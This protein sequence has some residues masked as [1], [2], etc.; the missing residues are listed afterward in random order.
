[1]SAGSIGAALDRAAQPSF[2]R[3]LRDIPRAALAAL[4]T[5]MVA[6]GLTEGGGL[7]LLVPLLDL[8]QHGGG[9]SPLAR[10]VAPVLRAVGLPMTSGVLLCAFVVMVS[11][12]AWLQNRRSAASTALQLRWVD[13]M[14]GRAF[15]ALIGAEYSWIVRQRQSDQVSLLTSDINRVGVGLNAGLT[16]LATSATSVIYLAAAFLLAPAL[17]LVV[18]ACGGLAWW[19]LAGQRRQSIDLGRAQGQANRALQAQLQETLAGVKLAKIL[20]AER[21]LKAGFTTSMDA[22]REQQMR[23]QHSQGRARALTQVVA[24]V[25]LAG[26]VQVGLAVWG[27]P[28]SELLILAL[29]LARMIPMFS[30]AQQQVHL[31]LNALPA[32]TQIDALVDE[33]E[34]SAEPASAGP[35]PDVAS[36]PWI[37]RDAIELR[38]AT[39]WRDGRAAPALDDLTLRLAPR[40]TTAVIG[41]SGAGKTTLADVLAGLMPLT[42]GTLAVD[43][44]A[45]TGGERLR[46]RHAVAYVTQEV[47][48][49][50]DTVRNNLLWG[51]ATAG[52]DDGLL[53]DALR[54]AAAEFVLA[55]PQGLDTVIGDGG[56]MLSGGER[57]RLA[58]ARALLR[59]PSLLILDEATSALDVDN[60]AR[61]GAALRALHGNLTVLLIGHRLA[62][63]EHADQV[64]VMAHGRIARSG[65]WAAVRDLPERLP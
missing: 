57:Q 56:L 63:L 55:L 40:T 39:L 61:I 65:P 9:T 26:F 62:T 3:L 35:S 47:F 29:L 49:V 11:V 30:T 24:A 58:L 36:T 54:Q 64:V 50:H 28:L 1:M 45:V 33:G 16:L 34:A 46:W 25:F 59:Q 17:T 27:T 42:A 13:E 60:E 22:L 31:L 20:G 32:L 51:M 52:P 18:L 44:V 7:L 38:A 41:A 23:F 5:W 43:G 12:S 4:L 21:L 2:A 8:L 15:S 48:L 53:V 19:W 10:H 14:R 6:A 37:V